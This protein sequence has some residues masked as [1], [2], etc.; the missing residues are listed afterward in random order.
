MFAPS[1]KQRFCV[2]IDSSMAN[3][4]NSSGILEQIGQETISTSEFT[5][6]GGSFDEPCFHIFT[7]GRSTPANRAL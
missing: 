6:F 7:G 5:R 4:W 3:P 2:R 1:V